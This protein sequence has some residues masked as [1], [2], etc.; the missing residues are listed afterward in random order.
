MTVPTQTRSADRLTAVSVALQRIAEHVP[1]EAEVMRGTFYGA[2]GA[3][4][5]VQLGDVAAVRRTADGLRCGLVH[6]TC[7]PERGAI[8]GQLRRRH[9]WVGDVSSIPTIL[10]A[11]EDIEE[12]PDL[13]EPVQGAWFHEADGAIPACEAPKA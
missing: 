6:E 8:T 2:M 12:L 13:P 11:F 1:A 3:D 9:L 7:D 10:W 5:E 4:I